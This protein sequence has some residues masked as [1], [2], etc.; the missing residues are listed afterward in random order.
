MPGCCTC[1]DEEHD[2]KAGFWPAEHVGDG[3]A[4]EAGQQGGLPSHVEHHH[5][6]AL[7]LA[8]DA[9]HHLDGCRK[10]G[11]HFRSVL[12]WPEPVLALV[13]TGGGKTA[14]DTVHSAQGGLVLISPRKEMLVLRA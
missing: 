2:L 10:E 6:R 5:V 8:Q 4:E 3:C 9:Q 13:M 12:P 7:G 14:T 11:L 1:E